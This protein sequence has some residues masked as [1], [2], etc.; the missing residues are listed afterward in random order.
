ML[1]YN[2]LKKEYVTV[3]PSEVVVN[4][5]CVTDIHY[6]K[7][8]YACGHVYYGTEDEYE[9]DPSTWYIYGDG[10]CSL[11]H[12]GIVTLNWDQYKDLDR[13][14]KAA[15]N[16]LLKAV[17]YAKGVTEIHS[18]PNGV[19]YD[20]YIYHEEHIYVDELCEG[21]HGALAHKNDLVNHGL[22]AFRIKNV[23]DINEALKRLDDIINNPDW[24]VCCSNSSTYIG[25]IGVS[26]YGNV[27]AYYPVDVWSIVD[28]DSSTRC[29]AQRGTERL[30]EYRESGTLL[31]DHDEYFV[32][33]LNPTAIWVKEWYW[34]QLSPEQRREIENKVQALNIE[35]VFVEKRHV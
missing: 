30:K 27:V 32:K 20:M 34:E 4:E 26:G 6:K 23:D 24:E 5:L 19:I 25:P 35:L 2:N 7:Y 33:Y 22:Q 29:I 15:K 28:G 18:N 21:C 17:N 12:S 3:N 14:G 8:T 1:A 13:F 31:S 10:S 11:S 16:N 9:E